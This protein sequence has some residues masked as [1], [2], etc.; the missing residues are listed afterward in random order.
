MTFVGEDGESQK[1]RDA[2]ASAHADNPN[3]TQSMRNALMLSLEA[4]KPPAI[5]T[6]E[7]WL[8]SCFW[9]ISTGRSYG[10]QG[11]MGLTFMD[12]AAFCDVVGEDLDPIEAQCIKSI[13]QAYLEAVFEE[14]NKARR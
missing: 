10:S 4:N 2:K 12:I 8:I 1:Q 9:E 5:N 7:H 14:Q 6:Y 13:D 3:F 11:P